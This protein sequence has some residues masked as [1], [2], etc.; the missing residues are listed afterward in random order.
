M[1]DAD[2]VERTV[3]AIWAEGPLDVLVNNAAG[4]FIARSEELSPRATDAVL[5]IVLHGSAYCTTACGRRWLASGHRGT[6]L[7][8]ITTYAWTGSAYVLPLAMAEGST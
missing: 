4:N 2:A 5:G 3:E 8:I 1:R 6:V 7:S